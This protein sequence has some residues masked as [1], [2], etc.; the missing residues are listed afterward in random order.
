MPRAAWENGGAQ[1]Q[2]SLDRAA[3]FI[4]RHYTHPHPKPA[5]QFAG[6]PP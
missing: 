4:L 3:D 2:V 1:S 5:P 6:T